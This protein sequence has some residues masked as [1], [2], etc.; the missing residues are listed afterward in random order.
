LLATIKSRPL[1]STIKISG[2]L[3]L[4]YEVIFSNE[5][6]FT[7]FPLLLTKGVNFLNIFSLLLLKN[8]QTI[9]VTIVFLIGFQPVMGQVLSKNRGLFVGQA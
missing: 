1:K 2:C 3:P 4:S 8:N 6:K 5:Q 9:A 7:A